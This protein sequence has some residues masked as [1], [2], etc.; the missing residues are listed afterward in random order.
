MNAN[1][2]SWPPHLVV[3]TVVEREGRYLFVE[4]HIGSDDLVINQPAG[5]WEPGESLF[6]AARRETLEETAWQVD[7]SGFL[8]VYQHH[9]A[10]LEYGFLRFAFLARALRHESGRELDQGIARAVWLNRE[11]LVAQSH[12]HRSPMVLR[13]LDDALAGVCHPLSLIQPLPDS[14]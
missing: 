12:R 2:S 9:P 11:E 10:D 8:G 14:P 7:L 3:A 13:C 1:T 6:D 5:H 4:E